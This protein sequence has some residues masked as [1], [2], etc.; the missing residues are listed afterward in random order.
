[1]IL[2]DTS[3]W[4]DHLRRSDARLLTELDR[5]NILMHPFVVGELALGSLGQR[6]QT[7]AAIDDLPY[8][9]LAQADEVR[10]LIE[11]K[12]LYSR[13]IGYSDVHLIASVLLTP[14]ATLWTR[15]R[16]LRV[17]AET[18]KIHVQFP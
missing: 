14:D 1:M 8:A 3:V 17:V 10:R 2:A 13:G 5:R 7:L 11:H 4:V 9:V 16:R 12:A 6:K 15:D 18:M